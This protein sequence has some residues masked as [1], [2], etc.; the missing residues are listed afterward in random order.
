MFKK[1]TIKV[2]LTTVVLIG[3]LGLATVIVLLSVKESSDALLQAQFDKLNTVESTKHG[4]IENYLNTLK[5]LLTSLAVQEGTHQAFMDFDDG[6]Y[7]LSDE[8]KLN[9]DVV[10]E[11][12]ESD[13]SSHYLDEVN[14]KVPN[15]KHRKD[16]SSYLPTDLNALVAQYIFITDNSA[17]LGEK[18]KM[19]D[20]QKYNSTYMDAHKKYHNSFDKFLT[21]YDLYDIF[22]VDLE[23]NIIYTDFKEKDFATNLKTGV[24]AD[25]AIARVYKKALGLKE[26]ALAFAD[27]EPYEP[28]YNAPASFIATPIFIKGVKKGVLI[29]QMPVDKINAIMNF[30]G[31]LKE[32]RLGKSGE[33]YLVGKDYK[34][35]SNSR[36]LDE[37]K[38]PIVQQFHSTIGIYEVKTEAMK[39]AM[40]TTKDSGEGIVRDYRGIKSLHVYDKINLFDQATWLIVAEMDESEALSPATSLRNSIVIVSIVA[41]FLV[42]MSILFFLNRVF[43]KP[44]DKFQ[45]GLLYFFKYLNREVSDISLLTVH[46]DDEIG[47]MS[48]TVNEN[49]KKIKTGIEED[50]KVIDSTIGVLSQFEEGDLFQRVEVK[51]A[52]P[53]LNELT[54][55][56]NKMGDTM[57]KNIEN[58]LVILDEYTHGN[59][60]NKTDTDGTKEHLF[61]LADGVNKLG[62]AI[63]SMLVENRANGINLQSSSNLLLKNVSSLNSSTAQASLSLKETVNVLEKITKNVENNADNTLKMTE[64]SSH[65]SKAVSTGETLANKTIQAIDEINEEVSSINEAVSIIDKITLQTNILSLNAAVEASTAGEAGKGFGVVAIEVRHLAA[66]TAEASNE[67]KKL[68]ENATQKSNEGKIIADEMIEGY[69][70][71]SEGISQ[72]IGL[73]NHVESASQEQLIGIQQINQTVTNL[74][75]HSKQNENIATKT[76]DIALDTKSIAKTIFERVD[77]KKFV[78]KK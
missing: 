11:E 10:K 36:F 31:K 12:L 39:S 44:L 2:Y 73:I 20:N 48:K 76:K 38:N 51:S 40:N 7:K 28:S 77:T 63:T 24:Y 55:L 34:M 6:F 57:Q 68:I 43:I 62:D 56:L 5:S 35:R 74:D 69:S 15:S 78:G 46:R 32:A 41:L 17:K 30:D 25:T 16:V 4:E 61:L 19:H 45:N 21:S 75:K 64:L 23:A 58:I 54:T 50:R 42:V 72:T 37:I 13:F 49:I 9:M 18:N 29:F 52:N 66:K 1:G 27:F 59:F 67:I 3:F 53:S 22:M 60:T 8:L 26:G 70:N 47:T 14:Y 33:C 65:V 71:L